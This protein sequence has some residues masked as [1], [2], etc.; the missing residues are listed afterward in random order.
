MVVRRRGVPAM[1]TLGLITLLVACASTYGA[2]SGGAAGTWRPSEDASP[3]ER[4]AGSAADTAKRR[5]APT[6]DG[7]GALEACPPC[8][9]GTCVAAGCKGSAT[10]N[11]CSKPFDITESTSVLA[12]VCP[13]AS[14]ID[15]SQACV[16]G[17]ATKGVH[18]A[19]F[20]MGMSSGPNKSWEVTLPMVA[21]SN[22]FVAQG[23]T[24]QGITNC[25]GGTSA[26]NAVNFAGTPTVLIGTTNPLTTCQSIAID[27]TMK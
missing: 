19:A 9:G 11:G 13:E 12:F 22:T 21:G 26:P 2:A 25:S 18:V 23:T 16:P 15:F 24:C 6:A 14:T 7:G 1:V 27:F 5:D 10:A 8:C 4:D 20:R 17:G 3:S